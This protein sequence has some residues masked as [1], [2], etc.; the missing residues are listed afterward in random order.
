MPVNN[1]KIEQITTSKHYS[2]AARSDIGSR[3][4]QQDQAY[5]NI[6]GDCI[7]AVVCDGMGGMADGGRASQ[8]AIQMMVQGFQG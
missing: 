6:K 4:Q 2:I 5:L 7:F 1:I 3:E 8:T